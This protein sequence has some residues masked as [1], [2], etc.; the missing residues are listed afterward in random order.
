MES[1][2]YGDDSG[3]VEVIS[4]NGM[5]GAKSVARSALGVARNSIRFTLYAPRPTPHALHFYK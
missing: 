3:G 5:Q 1:W 4:F 2:R